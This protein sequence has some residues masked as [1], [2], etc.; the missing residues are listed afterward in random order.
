MQTQAGVTDE[1]INVAMRK[2]RMTRDWRAPILPSVAAQRLATAYRDRA[3][4]GIDV[5]RGQRALS[6]RKR[7]ESP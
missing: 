6:P 1:F 5:T 4:T 2:M 7:R 3:T